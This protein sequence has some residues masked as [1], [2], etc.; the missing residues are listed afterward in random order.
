M[1]AFSIRDLREKTGD[2]VRGAE[3]GKLAL[4]SKRGNPLFVAVPF[5][6]TVLEGGVKVALAL[7][8]VADG[9]ISQGT[10]AELA[11]MS[12]VDFLDLMA[13]HRVPAAD[14]S[15]GDL[16]QELAELGSG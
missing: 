16:Q 7:R 3:A 12:R 6:G 1:K 15:A 14:Y 8:L 5:N 10:G 2:L 13:R 4:V 9:T 11:G